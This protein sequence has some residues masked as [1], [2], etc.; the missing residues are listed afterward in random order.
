MELLQSHPFNAEGS[1]GFL[2]GG[3]SLGSKLSISEGAQISE[4][5]ALA[6]RA[7]GSGTA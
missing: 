4:E 1:T 2:S 3:V 5:I 6:S 7:S